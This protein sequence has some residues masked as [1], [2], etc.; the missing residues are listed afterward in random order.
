[1][2]P[3]SRNLPEQE[4]SI[5]ARAH[6][7]FSEEPRTEVRKPVRPFPVILRETPAE[8]FSAL[9]KAVL[10]IAGVIVAVLFVAAL[11]RIVIRHGPK[12]REQTAPHAVKSAMHSNRLAPELVRH[13]PD[14]PAVSLAAIR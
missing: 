8:P 12:R 1:M 10:V 5:K 4:F 11:W 6:E 2:S 7:V 3:E 9:T 13:S 14:E